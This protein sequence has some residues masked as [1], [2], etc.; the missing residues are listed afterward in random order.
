MAFALTVSDS[1]SGLVPE[2]ASPIVG[3]RTK[4]T[5]EPHYSLNISWYWEDNSRV[6]PLGTQLYEIKSN[7]V[8][9]NYGDL[10]IE[11]PWYICASCVV[12]ED[13]VSIYRFI[14]KG[15]NWRALDYVDSQLDVTNPWIPV[16]IQEGKIVGARDRL[17][18]RG[19]DIATQ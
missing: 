18:L 13:F 17:W 16:I 2:I 19:S 6:T 4:L 1:E 8:S 12:T 14:D 7:A 11:T 9:L 10:D 3:I 5:Y 15:N